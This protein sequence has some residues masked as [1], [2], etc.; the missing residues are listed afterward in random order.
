MALTTGVDVA[1]GPGRV[2]ALGSIAIDAGRLGDA[3]AGH[4]GRRGPRRNGRLRVGLADWAREC[5]LVLQADAFPASPE[6]APQGPH[7]RMAL[8]RSQ[9][10]GDAAPIPRGLLPS[11]SATGPAA[12]REGPD[13][14][15]IADTAVDRHHRDRRYAFAGLIQFLHAG[16]PAVPVAPARRRAT[17]GYRRGGANET[18]PTS[19]RSCSLKLLLGE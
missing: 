16:G 3:G 13:H 9:P 2:G 15:Y 10:A 17:P 11:A 8:R 4:S 14:E 6:N 18:G 19:P 1:R 5:G 12:R 7:D